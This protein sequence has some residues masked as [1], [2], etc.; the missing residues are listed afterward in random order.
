MI[1]Y[2]DY[3]EIMSSDSNHRRNLI[4]SL[5]GYKSLNLIGAQSG[6]GKT[7]LFPFS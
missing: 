2:F 7:N 1:R 5:S 3:E 4:N 6:V